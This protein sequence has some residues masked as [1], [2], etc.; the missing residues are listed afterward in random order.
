MSFAMMDRS[1][2]YHTRKGWNDM[3]NAEYKVVLCILQHVSSMTCGSHIGH[4]RNHI[5][6]LFI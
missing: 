2:T 5:M 6:I 4:T 3:T 1:D